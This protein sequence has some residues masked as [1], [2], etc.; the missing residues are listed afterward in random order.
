MPFSF[1]QPPTKKTEF[2]NYARDQSIS[3]FNPSSSATANDIDQ[4]RSLTPIAPDHSLA[5]S[6]GNYDDNEG[7]QEPLL[8]AY[9]QQ[10]HQIIN[11]QPFQHENLSPPPNYSQYDAQYQTNKT[12]LLSRDRHLN[13]DGE[14]LAQFFQQHNIPP[15]MKIRFYG[16][17]DETYYKSKNVRDKHDNWK[18]QQTPVTKRV[19]DFNFDLDCSDLV[20]HQCQ[21]V[22]VLPDP[23]TGQIK[24]VRQLCD[25]YVREA[26]Q[27]KE[28]QLTKVIHWDYAKLTQAFT[29]AIRGHGYYHHV[30]ISYEL[31]DHI[32]T[33]KTDS[34]LSKMA[35]HWAV[36][37]FFYITFL[38]IFTWPYL[39]FSRKKFGD[40]TL[41]S[42]WKMNSTEREWYDQHIQQVLNQISPIPQ[43]TNAPFPV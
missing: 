29:T 27:F 23:K 16:Y 41:K 6:T 42:E 7:D 40:A 39:W 14:A 28:I 36:R 8:N 43:Y 11:L 38:F 32:I 4:Y 34:K 35:D 2:T 15:H 20:S 12:G 17:H 13:H 10:E 22:Y 19:K 30:A 37:L 5:D 33:I 21:R 26:N 3:A 1:Q 9:G 31:T 18:E 24:T 25:D